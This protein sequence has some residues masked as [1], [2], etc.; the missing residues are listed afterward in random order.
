MALLLSLVA[1]TGCA[2]S[3]NAFDG[4]AGDQTIE[5]EILNR[6]FNDA[7]VHAIRGG[8]RLRLGVVTG[9]TSNT[10]RLEWPSS[11][12][13]QLEIDLLAGR[14]C[15]TRELF[16]DPGEAIYLEIQPVLSSSDCVPTRA[17]GA[18]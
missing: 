17:P 7:T 16:V 10:L 11:R 12:L 15:V 14:S 4:S 18:R 6:N 8:E 3:G 13:L 2:S 1:V 9:K 5:I